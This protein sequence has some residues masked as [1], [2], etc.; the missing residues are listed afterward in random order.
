MSNRQPSKQPPADTP[1]RP[2]SSSSRQQTHRGQQTQTGSP[3][4]DGAGAEEPSQKQTPAKK[5]MT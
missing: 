4:V 3:Q 5:R 1:G 2:K